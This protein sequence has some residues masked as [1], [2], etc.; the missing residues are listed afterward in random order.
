MKIYIIGPSG[1]GKTTLSKKLAKKYNTECY[2]LD[3]LVYDDE[4]DHVKRSDSEVERLFNKIINKKS[5]IIEDVGRSRFYKGLDKCDQIY[6]L[7]ISKYRVYLRVVKRWFKQRLG[8]EKYNYPPT[9][10]QF[11]DMIR[12]ARLYFKHEKD[13]L[14]KL[15]EYK[16]KVVYLTYKDLN[17]F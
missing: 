17:T 2:E 8:K 6:Y 3:C 13:K 12:V 7:K 10:F 9:L 4:H 15:D 11:Y 1:S 5:W 16:D 14:K